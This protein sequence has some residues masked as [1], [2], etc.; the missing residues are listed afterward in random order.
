[1]IQYEFG[2]KNLTIVSQFASSKNYARTKPFKSLSTSLKD[3]FI[4]FRKNT[5]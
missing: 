3:I 2:R 5:I 1:M 4:W